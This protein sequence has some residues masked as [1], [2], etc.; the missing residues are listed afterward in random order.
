MTTYSGIIRIFVGLGLATLAACGPDPAKE[1]LRASV[2]DLSAR[3]GALEAKVFSMQ[4]A[5]QA[6][7][8]APPED[9]NDGSEKVITPAKFHAGP[10]FF[11][12]PF[13][14]S[15]KAPI[16]VMAFSNFQC[17]PCRLFHRTTFQELREKYVT[18]DSVQ[19]VFRDFPLENNEWSAQAAAMAH[20]AG[21]G[22][23]YWKMF[24]LLAANEALIDAG[25][26]LGVAKKYDRGLAERLMQCAKSSRYADEG[27]LDQND[28][29]ALGAKGAPGIFVGRRR[30]DSD[31]YQGV[32]IRGAQPA[33]LIEREV[34][35][36]D[37]DGSSPGAASS[38]AH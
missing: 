29:I 25:D 2:K 5:I 19:L 24:D 4:E 8:K 3:V 12:D 6:A 28:G 9:E 26:L 32:F 16:L 37:R 20:C 30:G 14:G 33:A 38:A 21:E 1:E 36:L 22:G 17:K 13:V 11:D 27:L 10:S 34:R 18:S 15:K 31:D 23:G 35:R 7:A